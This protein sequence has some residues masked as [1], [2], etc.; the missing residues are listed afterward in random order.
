[1]AWGRGRPVELVADGRCIAKGLEG[2]AAMCARQNVP[3]L[4]VEW[5]AWRATGD[6]ACHWA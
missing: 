2:T 6:L 1:M 3:R 5:R 4:T